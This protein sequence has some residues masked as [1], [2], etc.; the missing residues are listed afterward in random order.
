MKFKQHLTSEINLEMY[1]ALIS[2][3]TEQ[4]EK[5]GDKIPKAHILMKRLRM[6]S[7]SKTLLVGSVIGG[8]LFVAWFI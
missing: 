2:E 3:T 6:A 8:I 7:D 4:L 5:L 1:K